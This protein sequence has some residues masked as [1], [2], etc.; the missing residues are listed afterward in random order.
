M[1]Q[2]TSI[3]SEALQAKIRELLPSQQGFG[4]D[5]QASN[6]ILPVIDLTAAAAG[7]ATPE[8]LQTALA[9]GSQT[10][11]TA[12]NS[13]V[14]L[15]NTAGFWRLDYNITAVN[16]TAAAKSAS[17]GITDG[18]GTKNITQV[19]M[20]PTAQALAV[21]ETETLVV[22][23]RSGDSLTAT[24]NSTRIYLNAT[25]RQIANVNGQLVYPSGFTPQ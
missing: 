14:T 4:E 16:E 21:T 5:L 18:L 17:I 12:N 7:T 6:V 15:A 19:T 20:F 13:T 8:I 22:F 11:N 24:T 3:T 9:F 25:V 10:S 23:L 2:I 1:A